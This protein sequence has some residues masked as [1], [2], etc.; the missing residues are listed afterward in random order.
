LE[1]TANPYAWSRITN[2]LWVEYPVGVGFTTGNINITALDKGD[3]SQ[4]FVDFYKNWVGCRR[5]LNAVATTDQV[6]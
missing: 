1:P 3:I 4:D 6:C 5:L 2:M